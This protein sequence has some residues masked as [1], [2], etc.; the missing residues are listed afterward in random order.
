MCQFQMWL[1]FAV[2][3]C[4]ISNLKF[5][6]KNVPARN[7]LLENG[8]L[9]MTSTVLA[10]TFLGEDVKFGLIIRALYTKVKF[11]LQTANFS[12]M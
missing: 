4:E 8:L 11:T 12:Q 2:K 5:E 10:F 6:A 7:G 3:F 9:E 1:K